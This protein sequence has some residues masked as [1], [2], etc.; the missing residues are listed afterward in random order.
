MASVWLLMQIPTLEYAGND[1]SD[2][3]FRPAG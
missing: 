3:L 1:Q 2:A